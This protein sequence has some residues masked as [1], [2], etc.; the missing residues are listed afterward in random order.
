MSQLPVDDSHRA[1]HHRHETCPRGDGSLSEVRPIVLV[2]DSDIDL[3]V[4]A[5]C[6]ERSRILNPLVLLR[7]GA[8]FLAFLE[9]R[10]CRKLPPPALVL[11]DLDMPGLDGLTV[12]ERIRML[13]GFVTPLRVM[14]VSHCD[15]REYDAQAAGADAF[16]NK[17]CTVDGY[18]RFF[19]ELPLHW[20]DVYF[21]DATL[22]PQLD[23]FAS[24]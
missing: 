15:G 16:A 24:V 9:E 20:E 21:E 1:L 10:R 5:R 2:D 22:L 17:P 6:H 4:A 11:L 18:V 13:E 12:L 8:P 23:T 14:I 7:G 19:N 3:F